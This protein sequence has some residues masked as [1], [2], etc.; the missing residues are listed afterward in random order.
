MGHLYQWPQSSRNVVGGGGRKNVRWRRWW[1]NAGIGSLLDIT[2]LFKTQIYCSYGYLQQSYTQSRQNQS[3][4]QAAVIGLS[5]S[6]E[7]W[8]KRT[9][10]WEGNMSKCFRLEWEGGLGVDMIH[11]M[12]VGNCQ[13]VNK[14]TKYSRK[15]FT[16]QGTCHEWSL[17]V[18]KSP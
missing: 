1:R 4:Q 13:G 3:F 14:R 11:C 18:G 10:G 7:K 16:C 6:R 15:G 2:W 9:Q 12:H 5:G 8:G 17:E